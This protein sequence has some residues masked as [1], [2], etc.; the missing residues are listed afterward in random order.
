MR[1]FVWSIS[2]CLLAFSLSACGRDDQSAADIARIRELKEAE[3]VEAKKAKE[4]NDAHM[5]GLAAP[6]SRP[7]PGLKY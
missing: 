4:K 3:T 5:R 6:A 1:P 2:A 7:S